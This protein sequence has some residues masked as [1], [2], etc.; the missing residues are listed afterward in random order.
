MGI[1]NII[2]VAGS[3]TLPRAATVEDLKRELR[4][5]T[6]KLNDALRRLSLLATGSTGSGSSGVTSGDTNLSDESEAAAADAASSSSGQ[7]ARHFLLMGN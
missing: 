4:E 6:V 5:L 2:Q 7:F 3:N 1:Y